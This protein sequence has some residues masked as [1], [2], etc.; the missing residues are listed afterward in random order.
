MQQF[1]FDIE[2]QFTNKKL[3]A[4]TDYKTIDERKMNDKKVMY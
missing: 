1:L 3:N 2:I 4:L